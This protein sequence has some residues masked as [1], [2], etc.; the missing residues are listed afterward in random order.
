MFYSVM[1]RNWAGWY[2]ISRDL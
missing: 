1:N 2:T